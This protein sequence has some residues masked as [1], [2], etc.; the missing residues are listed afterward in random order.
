MADLEET[1]LEDIELQSR[2]WQR[3]IDDIVSIWEHG[4]EKHPFIKTPTTKFTAEWSKEKIN[5]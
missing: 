4:E 5:F 2:V 3:Y 1:I